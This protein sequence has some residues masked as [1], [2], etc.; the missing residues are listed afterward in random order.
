M[1]QTEAMMRVA[2]DYDRVTATLVSVVLTVAFV[3]LSILTIG[4]PD[5]C[6]RLKHLSMNWRIALLD[7]GFIFA[8]ALFVLAMQVIYL[9]VT[10]FLQKREREK[11]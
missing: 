1:E 2:A 3:G 4:V 5:V 9:S 8:L 10:D 11:F 7:I 6:L